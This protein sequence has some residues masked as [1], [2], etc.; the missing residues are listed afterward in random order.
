MNISLGIDGEPAIAALPKNELVYR[1]LRDHILRDVFRQG[2]VLRQGPVSDA[3]GVGRGPASEALRKLE[4]DGLIRKRVGHGFLVSRDDGSVEPVEMDLARAGLTLPEALKNALG[5]RKLKAHIY[6]IVEQEVASLLVFGRFRIN[7][8]I[9]AE[10][11][12]VSRTVAQEILNDL[13]AVGLVKHGSNGR[14]YAGPLTYEKIA[15]FYEMRWILE[16]LALCQAAPSIPKQ[17]LLRLRDDVGEVLRRGEFEPEDMGRIETD[18]HNGLVLRC[19]NDELRNTL[20]RCQ[21]PIISTFDTVDRALGILEHG[22]GLREAAEDHATVLD[23]LLKRDW[24]SA[25]K[26]L[27]RHLHRAFELCGPHFKDLQGAPEAKIPP[28]L[29]PER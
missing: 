20:V 11:F 4:S 18:L 13:E 21:L 15:E 26:A 1:I 7:Q 22:S 12:G 8:S 16:P 5:Q 28:Y 25:A 19:V 17:E 14:W 29:T 9:M 6:P 2:L 23:Y 10:H 3:F 24:D 27:E